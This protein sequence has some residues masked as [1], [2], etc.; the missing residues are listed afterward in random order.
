VHGGLTHAVNS[1]SAKSEAN[2]VVSAVSAVSMLQ[3]A[4]EIAMG[5]LDPYRSTTQP[6]G[7]W[8]RAY[9]QKNAEPTNPR[10]LLSS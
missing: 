4:N 6:A 8:N 1:R 2:P 10:S 3:R 7:I 9:D 5:Y